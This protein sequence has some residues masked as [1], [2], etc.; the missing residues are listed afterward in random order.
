MDMK[1]TS[2]GSSRTVDCPR[3]SLAF[4]PFFR[5]ELVGELRAFI[6]FEDRTSNEYPVMPTRTR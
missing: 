1:T 6:V 2:L 5:I 4:I 3:S